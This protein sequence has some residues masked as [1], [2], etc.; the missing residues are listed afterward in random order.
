MFSRSLSALVAG[1]AILFASP[2]TSQQVTDIAWGTSTVGSAGHKALVALATVLNREMKEYRVAVQ[3]TPGAIVTIKGYATGQFDGYFGSDIAFYELHNDTA[4][5][6]GFKS[7]IKRQPVQSFW[8]FT[9]ECGFG[10]SPKEIGKIKQWRD[11][12]GKNVF[13]GPLPFDTRAQNE[14]ALSVL[15]VNKEYV[16]VDLSSVASVVNSGR[17]SAFAI[18]TSAESTPPPW[19]VEASLSADWAVLNPSAEEIA[20]LKKAGFSTVEVDTKVFKRDVHAAKATLLPFYYGFHVGLEMSE[21][22][23]YRMLKVIEANLAELTSND[24]SFEQIKANMAEMQ[25]RG[26]AASVDYVP[27]H[28]GLAKYMREKGVWDSKWDNRIAQKSS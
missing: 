7:Q 21:E 4:R 8:A 22:N 28:P 10:I 20:E 11:L 27:I 13:T 17:I 2:A 24:R 5:F 26:V 16:E 12:S 19:L 18:Y 6:K 15:K 9:L 3:P 1:T 25:R 23:V 14:R